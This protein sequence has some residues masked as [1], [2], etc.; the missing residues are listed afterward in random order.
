MNL[1]PDLIRPQTFGTLYLKVN[2]CGLT[3]SDWQVAFADDSGRTIFSLNLFMQVKKALRAWSTAI[4]SIF[5]PGTS[6]E[7]G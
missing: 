6:N 4:A 1:Q 7:D 5:L 2:T 3:G